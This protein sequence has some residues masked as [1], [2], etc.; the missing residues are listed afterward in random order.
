MHPTESCGY[1]F[2]HTDGKSVL[3]HQVVQ[4]MIKSG[5]HAF[6]YDFRLYDKETTDSKIQL[7]LDMVSQLPLQ[8]Q[9]T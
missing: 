1:H 6:P 3:G 8:K 5:Q 4:L 2:S 7:L 9:S